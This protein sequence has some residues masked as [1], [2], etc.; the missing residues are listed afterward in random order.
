MREGDSPLTFRPGGRLPNGEGRCQLVKPAAGM[1]EYR[2]ED[3]RLVMADRA[4]FILFPGM[5]ADH[6]LFTAQRGS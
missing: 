4:R 1:V 2:Q 5:G 6:R 3:E